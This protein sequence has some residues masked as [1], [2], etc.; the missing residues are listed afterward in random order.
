M[1]IRDS[2]G[3]RHFVYEAKVASFRYEDDNSAKSNFCWLCACSNPWQRWR[4]KI[5]AM[6]F[7]ARPS[8]RRKSLKITLWWKQGAS[9]STSNLKL[10]STNGRTTTGSKVNKRE[11]RISSSKNL[12][13]TK[14]FVVVLWRRLSRRRELPNFKAVF[15]IK[16]CVFIVFFLQSMAGWSSYSLL[17][18]I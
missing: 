17:R 13:R 6:N 3:F 9:S 7:V 16:R 11:P 4:D 2:I 8:W 10:S 15:L 18:V 12:A 14:N 5:V 1:C